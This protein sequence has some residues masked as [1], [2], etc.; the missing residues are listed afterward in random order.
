MKIRT[1]LILICVV[2]LF[3][4]CEQTA[5]PNTDVLIYRGVIVS[6]GTPDWAM[7]HNTLARVDEGGVQVSGDIP[8]N[9]V[10]GAEGE[11]EVY[12]ADGGEV[13][14]EGKWLDNPDGY[15]Y[16]AEILK[17][18]VVT[19]E[20]A[21]TVLIE[22]P[23]QTNFLDENDNWIIVTGTGTFQTSKIVTGPLGSCTISSNVRFSI[24]G[25]GGEWG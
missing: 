23:L 25:D 19:F 5:D 16:T 3:T 14:T 12:A 10:Y 7:D 8:E 13:L 15:A 9:T 6:E 22:N 18:T 24:G 21:A 11:S 4:A 20:Q 17:K 2:A 1:A